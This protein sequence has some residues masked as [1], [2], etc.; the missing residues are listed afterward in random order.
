[1]NKYQCFDHI[2]GILESNEC[3]IDNKKEIKYGIQFEIKREQQR[4]I[5]RIY[6]S[7]KGIRLDFS[8]IQDDQ[9]RSFIESITANST[10]HKTIIKNPSSTSSSDI[11]QFPERLIGIDESGK[12]DYFG[13]L[14]VAGVYTDEETSKILKAV[15]VA[16]SKKIADSR[17]ETLSKTIKKICPYDIVVISNEKYNELYST[18]K[19]LNKLLAWGHARVIENLLERVDCKYA[20]SDQ[21]GKPELI[22][23]ALMTKGRKIQLE[24]Q[25][26]AERNIAVAAASVLARD[27]F[28]RRIRDLEVKY[29]TEFPK[30]A[31]PQVISAAKQFTQ[32]HGNDLI[33]RVAKVHFK[34]TNQIIL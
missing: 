34:I 20:L 15:G 5:F 28:I 29:E 9:F 26:K 21:F 30:G 11:L 6:E 10:Y 4:G 12:G 2:K 33:H 16:D 32:Q 18:I 31:S 17:I 19:N 24:Q 27:E 14:V 8:Q 7:K 1:M 3:K 25:T 23:E 13:P 22:Q